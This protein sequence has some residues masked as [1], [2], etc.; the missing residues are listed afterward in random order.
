MLTM[1]IAIC[2]SLV[3][4]EDISS[5]SDKLTKAWHKVH[6]PEALEG[7]DEIITLEDINNEK[8]NKSYHKWVLKSDAIKNY[9]K[10]IKEADCILVVNINK[11]WVKNY[12]WW[13]SFL[14]MWFAHIH[15]KKIFMLNEIPDMIY[16]DEIIAMQPIILNRDLTKII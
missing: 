7:V 13:N 6:Y 10:I 5:I 14:E 11:N 1:K 9:E 15:N 12:I 2:W 16:T 3:F 8:D 4:S